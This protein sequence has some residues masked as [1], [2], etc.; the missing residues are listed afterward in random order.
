ME[1]KSLNIKELDYSET[2]D[3]NGGFV[4]AILSVI[5]EAVAVATVAI[6]VY[7]NA[8]DFAQGF[9]EGYQSAQKNN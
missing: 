9:K 2:I 4:I 6:Y 5:I 1:T 7:N 8:P 3:I